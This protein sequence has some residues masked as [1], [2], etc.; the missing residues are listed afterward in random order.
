M[1]KIWF[2]IFSLSI[3]LLSFILFSAET[4]ALSNDL[5][6]SSSSNIGKEVN[7]ELP[8][9]GLLPDSPLYFLRVIRD[10]TIGLLISDPL[11]KAEFNL[12]QSDKRFNAG[13]YLF[14]KGKISLALSTISKAENYFSEAMDKLGEAKTQNKNVNDIEGKLKN[15]LKK[16]E[17]EMVNMIKKIN[18]NDKQ[19]FENELKR[20]LSFEKRLSY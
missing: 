16:Y 10:K 5:S 18:K 11:K 14:N 20:L 2:L 7:Y 3:F 15:A 6:A 19:N 13:I 1:R 12:L 8:Y 9:P 17:Q 4:N